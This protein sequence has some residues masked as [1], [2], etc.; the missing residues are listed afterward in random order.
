MYNMT[1]LQLN[2]KNMDVMS[3]SIKWSDEYVKDT[4]Y[5]VTLSNASLGLTPL[6]IKE[7]I[8]SRL[9]KSFCLG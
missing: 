7:M 5:S 6:R 2:F 3:Q 8:N 1:T 4:N 9:S